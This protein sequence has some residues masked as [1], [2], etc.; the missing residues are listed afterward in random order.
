MHTV[1]NTNVD[2]VVI[3]AGSLLEVSG[4]VIQEG[5]PEQQGNTKTGVAGQVMLQPVLP[6]PIFLQPGRIQ[7]DG[8]FKI[9]GVSRDQYNVQVLGL[10]GG[11]YVKSVRAGNVDVTTS[12]LDLT[13]SETAPPL[14][15]R[16]SAKGATVSGVVLDGEKPSPGAVVVALA[17]PFDPN[18]RSAMQKTATTDQNGRF[19]LQGLAPGEYRVY[20]WDSY[21]LLNDLDTEQLKPFDKFAAAVKLKEEARE[22][23]ELKLASVARE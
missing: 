12:G 14:E 17:Q 2:D 9:S 18:R 4:L 8:T 10:S 11:Q 20:A 22:Q 7:E 15:I 13:S 1:T 23:L 3:Q 19:T 16:V 5:A 21:L 6:L